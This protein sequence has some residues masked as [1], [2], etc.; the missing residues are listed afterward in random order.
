[1]EGNKRE[2]IL[3]LPSYGSLAV[4]GA[5]VGSVTEVP[6]STGIISKKFEIAGVDRLKRAT[7]LV[8]RV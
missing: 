6:K 7:Q 3:N 4:D 2:V 5:F 1:M 8:V